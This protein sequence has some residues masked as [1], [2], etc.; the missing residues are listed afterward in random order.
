[1]AVLSSTTEDL[2]LPAHPV[3]PPTPLARDR[4]GGIF[5]LILRS[6]TSWMCRASRGYLC[7]P[8]MHRI[9]YPDE[10]GEA[11]RWAAAEAMSASARG[12]CDEELS[13]K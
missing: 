10:P 9:M 8:D 7:P 5:S 12:C 4:D 11:E 6:L 2:I 1:M 13:G 3:A